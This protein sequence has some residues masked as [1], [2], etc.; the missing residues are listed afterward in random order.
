MSAVGSTKVLVDAYRPGNDDG[1]E[2]AW[3]AERRRAAMH[4]FEALGLPTR[5]DEAWRFT[6]LRPFSR[7]IV[8][9]TKATPIATDALD[10]FRIGEPC[11]SLV[12]I[13]GHWAPELSNIGALP[14]GVWLGSLSDAILHRPDL[15][16]TA[17]DET[18]D[19]SF[20]SLNAALFTDGI[21]L[22]LDP[23]VVLSEVVELIHIRTVCGGPPA[24]LRH[25]FSLGAGSVATV[26]E[27]ALGVGPGS[28]NN[29]TNITVADDAKLTYVKLQVEIRQRSASGRGARSPWGISRT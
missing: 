6:D 22:A 16:T 5:R 1:F 11:H 15:V 17:F 26:V 20:A 12:F 19:Q 10:S 23:D 3:L 8:A 28:T 2:P 25:L 4:R 18:V 9:D 21:V 13:D 27:C 14:S 29:V 24:Q 7:L